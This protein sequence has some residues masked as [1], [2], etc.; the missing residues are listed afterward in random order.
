M[1]NPFLGEIKVMSFPF[2]PKGWAYCDGQIMPISQNTGLFSII[3]SAFGGD[4]KTTYGLPNLQDRVAIHRGQGPGSLYKIGETGGETTVKLD[5]QNMPSHTHTPL[6]RNDVADNPSPQNNALARGTGYYQ[7]AT[8]SNLVRMAAAA[9]PP[10]GAANPQP[11]NNLQPFL[12][13][14]YCIA[15]SGEMPIPPKA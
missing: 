13:L 5:G 3:G 9:L 11:H 7:N 15:L 10:A 1:A 4:G 6:A 8:T 2:A 14:N 12:V